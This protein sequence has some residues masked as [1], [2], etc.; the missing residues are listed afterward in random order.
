M[1][2][3][4]AGVALPECRYCTNF[5]DLFNGRA[6]DPTGVTLMVVNAAMRHQPPKLIN[7]APLNTWHVH[8]FVESTNPDSVLRLATI[9]S[10]TNE[11]P[12]L[13]CLDDGRFITVLRFHRDGEGL[14][15]FLARRCRDELWIRWLRDS[16]MG[17]PLRDI[18]AGGQRL[19][20]MQLLPRIMENAALPLAE[21]VGTV[22]QAVAEGLWPEEA[23][24]MIAHAPRVRFSPVVEK[25]L[26]I[27]T[28][29][30]PNGNRLHMVKL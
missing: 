6:L 26:R 2:A 23:A 5:N 27:W 15:D 28:N 7:T 11:H 24:A 22:F 30:H 16:Y 4:A 8:Q 25:C 12:M 29:Q 10:Q 13:T 3:L 1:P 9:E 20:A 14:V 21:H 17:I 19:D 18:D